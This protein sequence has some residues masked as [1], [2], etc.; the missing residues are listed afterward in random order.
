EC[1]LM[2]WRSGEPDRPGSGEV[3]T[4]H[5]RG[6]TNRGQHGLSAQ[7]EAGRAGVRVAHENAGQP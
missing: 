1:V 4:S 2:C 6:G 5:A 3:Q 7:V